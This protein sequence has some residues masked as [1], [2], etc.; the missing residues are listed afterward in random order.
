MGKIL[1]DHVWSGHRGVLFLGGLGMILGALSTAA[2]TQWIKPVMDDIFIGHRGD[3]LLPISMGVFLIFFL[4]GL[5]EYTTL[6]CTDFMGQN[7][8]RS[9]QKRLF[10]H[11]VAMNLDFFRKNHEGTLIS[12][13]THDVRVIKTV[14]IQTMVTLVNRSLTVIFL[15]T[16][17]VKS[18]FTMFWIALWLLPVVGFLLVYCQKKARHLN[19]KLAFEMADLSVFFQQI[20]QNIVLVKSSHA[21]SKELH[22]MEG[23]LESLWRKALA[24]SK[25]HSTIHP[26]MDMVAGACIAVGIYFVGQE[27][28]NGQQTVGDFFSF[29]MAL[30]FIYPPIKMIISLN[31][32]MQEGLVS[33]QR[34]HELLMIPTENSAPSVPHHPEIQNSPLQGPKSEQQDPPLNIAPCPTVPSSSTF[35][36]PFMEQQHPLS[37]SSSSCAPKDFL[38]VETLRALGGGGS[39]SGKNSHNHSPKNPTLDHPDL[40]FDHIHFQYPEASEPLYGDF[41]CRFEGGKKIALVGPSGTGKTTLFYLLLRLYKPQGG[42]ILLGDRDIQSLSLQDWRKN[43]AFVGQ[44]M[45]LFSDTIAANIAYGVS[46]TPTQIQEA[47]ALAHAEEFIHA[48]PEGYDTPIG[49]RGL[50]LSGGQR[51]RLALARAFLRNSPILLLDEAT[52]ALDGTSEKKIKEATFHLME[53]RTTVMI[54]HRLSTIEGADKIFVLDKGRVVQEGTHGELMGEVGLYQKWALMQQL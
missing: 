17:M 38:G 24:F 25:V 20:F 39:A 23:R 36:N 27:V 48:L 13:M 5:S 37:P 14:V 51:Q 12:L 1:R 30:V 28:M 45:A 41:S 11:V 10:T 32:Q 3:R 16:T 47:A 18:S 2:L 6:R 9:L 31:T 33:A 40:I 53:R 19:K 15:L 52:S 49:T 26:V 8:M 50:M 29:I 44:E 4:R 21:E 54:A 43:I 42:R 46:A 34:I 35:S 22:A 7:L